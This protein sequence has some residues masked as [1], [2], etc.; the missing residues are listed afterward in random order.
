[1][2]EPKV[3][4]GNAETSWL[5]LVYHQNSRNHESERAFPFVGIE[6]LLLRDIFTLLFVLAFCI[7]ITI[8]VKM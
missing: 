2:P 7:Y 6:M 3:T 1:M 8:A 5:G 4:Q